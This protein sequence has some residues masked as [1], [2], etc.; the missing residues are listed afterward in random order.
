MTPAFGPSIKSK[1]NNS[2]GPRKIA[3]APKPKHGTEKTP[4]A[5]AATQT[6]MEIS[7][8]PSR[9]DNQE[10]DRGPSPPLPKPQNSVENKGATALLTRMIK[11]EINLPTRKHLSIARSVLGRGSF[12]VHPSPPPPRVQKRHPGQTPPFSRSYFHSPWSINSAAVA[13]AQGVAVHTPLPN[14]RPLPRLGLPIPPKK[15]PTAIK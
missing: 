5:P 8:S 3:L 15:I 12:T 1:P 7:P 9:Q 11:R 6:K 13:P 4:R 2:E 10:Q 14:S